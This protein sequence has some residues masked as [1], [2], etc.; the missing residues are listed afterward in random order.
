MKFLLVAINAKYIHSNLAVYSLK[1]YAEK[2]AKSNHQIEIAEYTINQYT[3]EIMRD[4]YERKP[5]AIGFSCYIWNISMVQEI[6]ADYKK[7]CPNVDIWVGGPEVSY[8]A[9]TFLSHNSAIDYAMYGEGEEVFKNV[10]DAYVGNKMDK[11]KLSD[12]NGI[13]YREINKVIITEPEKPLDLSTIPF[14]YKNMS[15]F[16]NKIIYYETSR[17]CPFSCSYCLS[18]IDKKLR[19]RNIEL[20]KRELQF[21][22]DNHT[23]QVK[24]VDRTFNCHHNHAMGI[25]KFIKEHDNG[26]TNFHFEIAAD[27]ITKEEIDLIK[28]MRPGLIQ[29]EIGVQSTH[30]ETLNA[31]NR[32]TNLLKISQ[33]TSKIKEGKNIH[34]HLDLIAGLPYEDYETFANSLNQVY[35]MKPDQLQLGF[36]KV[37]H[38]SSMEEKAKEYGIVYRTKAP[39]EVL[40]TKWLSYDELLK[41]KNI[42]AVVEIYYNSF[43]FENTMNR[44][45]TCFHSA[46][47]MYE[48]LGQYYKENSPNGEKHSRVS[49]YELLL[50]FIEQNGLCDACEKMDDGEDD[51]KNLARVHE[52]SDIS[53][54]NHWKSNLNWKELLTLDF[55]LRENAKSRPDFAEDIS[56][57]KNEMKAFYK[58][59]AAREILPDYSAYD[60]R[61]LEKM[62]H[63]EIFGIDTDEKTYILFDYKNR[64]P[65]NKQARIV[66]VHLGEDNDKRLHKR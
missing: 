34:Q 5:D 37:L 53:E 9:E 60:H 63:L 10:L 1:A 31:V 44:L 23:A 56:D 62:T 32:R 17:G 8:N 15:E 57:Y 30:E 65:L 51:E 11:D 7:I 66:K 2:Y 52:V 22:I 14:A 13:A 6:A 4:I 42:E 61:Q 36:L 59:E 33:I 64:N 45:E 47:E 43:Q 21:F 16:K 19:F 29:L 3:D 38:G 55:Y 39:Y 46:F 25:W 27:L 41:L 12:I 50:G 20:V 40:Q 26:I 54:E 49:R 35:G 24:F 18:S 58:S 28:T 48:T